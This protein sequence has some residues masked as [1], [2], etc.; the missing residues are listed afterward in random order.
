MAEFQVINEKG[1]PKFAVLPYGDNAAIEDYLDT[2]WAENAV[3]EYEANPDKRFHDWD[4][5]L[6]M[7]SEKKKRK[8]RKS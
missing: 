1:K 2:L 5:V 6:R 7:L 8:A 3:K 4:D